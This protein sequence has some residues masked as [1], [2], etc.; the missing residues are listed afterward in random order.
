MGSD[1]DLVIFDPNEEAVISV[2]THHMRVDY[3]MFEGLKV[4]GVTKTVFSRGREIIRTE[5]GR[6]SRNRPIRPPP[7]ILRALSCPLND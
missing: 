1:A 4:K 2:A 6:Q 7:P 5:S 3:S